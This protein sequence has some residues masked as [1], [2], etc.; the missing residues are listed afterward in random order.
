MVLLIIYGCLGHHYDVIRE[1]PIFN[2]AFLF[3][4][5]CILIMLVAL[6]YTKV[7]PLNRQD[8]WAPIYQTPD[9]LG[10]RINQTNEV[11]TLP[12]HKTRNVLTKIIVGLLVLL[13][14]LVP[15]KDIL[16]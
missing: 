9:V 13:L 16:F 2:Y 14:M 11:L 10:Q 6:K 15:L 1:D 7:Y 12:R 5:C 4:C 3:L 8:G